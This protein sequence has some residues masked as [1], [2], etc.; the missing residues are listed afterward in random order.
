MKRLSL[1]SAIVLL[2]TALLAFS[3]ALADTAPSSHFF[4]TDAYR[5]MTWQHAD[6]R[7]EA[8][9][10][11]Y[12]DGSFWGGIDEAQDFCHGYY[13]IQDDGSMRLAV[14]HEQ[15]LLHPGKNNSYSGSSADGDAH[16]TLTVIKKKVFD[17]LLKK[18][19][20]ETGYIRIDI[21]EYDYPVFGMVMKQEGINLLVNTDWP[22][23]IAGHLPQGT[24]ARVLGDQILEDGS[25]FYLLEA[26]GLH[27]LI[28]W[29]DQFFASLPA[30]S[31]KVV[32]SS[33]KDKGRT[34]NIRSTPD[35]GD[36]VI[37]EVPYGE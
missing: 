4:Q 18:A 20:M 10:V 24:A 30:K 14:Q 11:F 19:S 28:P 3:A 12:P 23:A 13:Y 6:G 35:Y 9:A 15:Y 27:G 7:T 17:A 29:D 21:N 26:D 31:A 33:T 37:L 32:R 16:L 8:D 1:L 22:D 2:C 25:G 34:V 36:N 5:H